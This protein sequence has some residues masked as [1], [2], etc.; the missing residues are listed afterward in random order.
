[1]LAFRFSPPI[2]QCARP[3]ERKPK[4]CKNLARSSRRSKLHRPPLC[5]CRFFFFS[6]GQT[7][8]ALLQT[9]GVPSDNEMPTPL[10]AAIALWPRFSFRD[11]PEE[12]FLQHPK[13]TIFS[14][15]VEADQ[16]ARLQPTRSIGLTTGLLL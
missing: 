12:I 10:G 2:P 14:A 5:L 9:C 6:F 13:R 3:N 16:F 4:Y 7:L 8:G 15:R 11:S 1:M